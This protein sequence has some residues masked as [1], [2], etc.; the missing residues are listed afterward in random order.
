MTP[1]QVSVDR[2]VQRW[3]VPSRQRVI[4]AARRHQE[5]ARRRGALT[6]A[7]RRCAQLVGA[8]ALAG[9]PCSAVDVE[10]G[11]PCS[12]LAVESDDERGWRASE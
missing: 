7:A 8:R 1:R 4:L 6:S 9:G 2:R 5:A 11:G 12:A 3:R 10:I